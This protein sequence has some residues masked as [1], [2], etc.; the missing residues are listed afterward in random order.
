MENVVKE[1]YLGSKDPLVMTDRRVWLDHQ[2]Q[3]VLPAYAGREVNLGQGDSL[4]PKDPQELMVPVEFKDHQVMQVHLDHK[5][6]LVVK[7]PKALKE[8]QDQLD[9]KEKLDSLEDRVTEVH[10]VRLDQ[11]VNKVPWDRLEQLETRENVVIEEILVSL[12]L[13]DYVDSLE[14]MAS[15]EQLVPKVLRAVLVY[16]EHKVYLESRV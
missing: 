9:L 6:V 8:M 4:V 2:V 14:Q 5:V 1:V 10:Q 15:L 16:R 13:L 11:Q 7:V 12:V 3:K